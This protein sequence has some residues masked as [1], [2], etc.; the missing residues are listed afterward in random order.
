MGRQM[1]KAAIDIGT[2]SVLLLVA[3]V[4]DGTLQA[5]VAEGECITRLGRSVEKTGTLDR[6]AIADTVA[7][8]E[9]FVRQARELGSERILLAATS[10][11]REA[12]NSVELSAE[13]LAR[14]GLPMRVLSGEDEATLT[15][16]GVATNPAW[17]EGL[18]RVVDVGG[19]STEFI[20]GRGSHILRRTSVN[21]GH[22]RLTER[23]LKH[24]PPERG[25]VRLL[26]RTVRQCV[27]AAQ[28]EKRASGEELLAVGGTITTLAAIDQEL[29]GYDSAR[30]EGY[31]LSWARIRALRR[32]LQALPAS[33]R[34]H[35]T[36]L[37]PARA[38][39][40]VA[41]AAIF[42]TFMAELGFSRLRVTTRGLRH[43]LV[44]LDPVLP[45]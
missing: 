22:L 37:D 23:L 24:D 25:E 33:A 38:P 1:R 2:N 10:A 32:Q 31:A 12:R 28:M 44:V 8:V 19:G 21:I 15:F 16:A 4:V 26:M 9:H 18:L 5:V 36:G 45:A 7:A 35:V 39:V 20:Q 13:L 11:V 30:I 14:T 17:G 3:E 42:E 40:I 6:G 41:G 34:A 29:P 27:R 43:G